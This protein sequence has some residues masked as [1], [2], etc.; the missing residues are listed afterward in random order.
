MEKREL[1]KEDID[2]V[3]NTAGFPI[4]TDEDIIALS[5]APYYT[6]CPNPFIEEFIAEN[7]TPYDERTDDYKCEPFSA[8]IAVGKKDPIYNAHSYHTKVPYKAIMRYILHYTKPGDIIFDGFCGSGMTG[9]AAQMCGTNDPKTKFEM[10]AN[11]ENW[12]ARKVIL[13]DLS[14]IATNISF[15]NN[16][17]LNAEEF[18]DEFN[19]ILQKAI[20][21]CAWVY[22]TKD[23]KGKKHK[24]KYTVFSDVFICPQ[25]GE[26]IVFWD[27]AV[28]KTTG[29]VND[30]FRC[31]SCNTEL[32]KRE[33]S[34]AIDTYFDYDLNALQEISKQ[35]PV[36]IAYEYNNKEYLKIPDKEDIALIN[37]IND[38]SFTLWYPS[39][40]MCEGSE[41]RRNDKFGIKYVHQFFTKRNLYVLSYL[42]NSA[43]LITA[44]DIR[45]SILS[46][47]T[48]VMMGLSKLQRFRLNSGFPNMIQ[49]GTLYIGSL[50]REWNALDWIQGKFKSI[51]K[52]KNLIANFSYNNHIITT[53]SLT[54]TSLP[55]NSIDY[56]FTDPPFGFNLNYSEL[57]FI[58]EAWIKVRTNNETEAI[59]NGVQ[60]KGLFEYKE[61][62]TQCFKEYFRVLKPNHWM[63]VEFHNS[64]QSVWNAIQEALQS[65]GFIIADISILNKKQKT[66]KQITSTAAVD[67]DLIISAYKP[68]ESTVKNIELNAGSPETAFEFVRQ[69]LENLPV[70]VDTDNNGLLDII[71][72]RQAFLLF[73]RMVAYHMT[74]GMSVPI[75]A[76]AFYDGLKER[77]LERD[78]MYFLPSQV[79][80]YDLA[81]EMAKGVEPIQTAIIITDEKS[82]IGWLY[83]EL[84]KV[85]QKYS[86]IQ[87]KFLKELKT[88]N[89]REKLP[90][91][92]EMLE[93]N[94]LKDDG[95]AWYVPDI[96]KSADIAKL[97]EKNLLKEFQQYQ[98]A[99]GNIKVFRSEAV[100]VGFAKLWNDRNYAA[101]VD[102]AQ[103]L[104][105]ETIQ[106]DPHLLMFYDQSLERV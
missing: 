15:L 97:R 25:C 106:E 5:D 4:G 69:H 78:G 54:N 59:I 92:S 33:C 76:A 81:R 16:S 57:S 86:E 52:L 6:A 44:K 91:L 104:P 3:R 89:K 21:E 35:V 55:D 31:L 26:E 60:K 70:A 56:I 8:D 29:K 30:K 28:D 93:E 13:S 1:T 49:S 17:S 94:F 22:E 2:K 101:I 98:A 19:I 96:K 77:F 46:I 100:R 90:E 105:S 79:T 41:S 80:E 95:G 85:P 62:M 73:D 14:P 50:T 34:K 87:P 103:K 43:L 10:G 63:T 11:D 83:A 58:W 20:K 64:K 39:E 38:L 72:E 51:L 47:L 88:L 75:D 99:K 18:I 23:N 82:A 24:I 27:T 7:G 36:L 67:Q 53:N 65:A 40:R 32:T 74:R 9:V 61:L 84:G 68:K 12:G 42:W 102:M 71:S 45:I 66:F 37:K 48:G